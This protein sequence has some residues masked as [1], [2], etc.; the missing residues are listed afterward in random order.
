MSRDSRSRTPGSLENR[1][2]PA[3]CDVCYRL[4]LSRTAAEARTLGFG[5]FTTTLLVSPYQDLRR[6]ALAGDAAALEH[7]VL[8]LSE[9]MTAG[10][11][12]STQTSRE[13][14]LYRQSY[15]GCVYSEK[16]R[17]Q[18]SDPPRP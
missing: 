14:G 13:I 3:R 7:G 9:D 6:I 16:E 1:P 15:C 12:E 5:E 2:A 18:K 11:R 17:Y 8:F 4:R 10:Y